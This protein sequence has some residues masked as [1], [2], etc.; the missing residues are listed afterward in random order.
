MK[1]VL[2]QN[3]YG[4]SEFYEVN[5]ADNEAL[6]RAVKALTTDEYSKEGLAK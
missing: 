3:L 6:N 2:A 5:N 1:A 4:I